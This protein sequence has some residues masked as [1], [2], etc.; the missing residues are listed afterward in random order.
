MTDEQGMRLAIDVCRLG[1]EAGQSPFGAVIVRDG[2]VIASTHNTVWADT[3]PSAHAEVNVIRAAC[4]R[5]GSI[6]LEGC[7]LYST[8]EPCPMC[9]S[10]SHWARLDRVVFGASIHDAASAG[11]SELPISSE[12]MVELGQSPLA[13]QR[14][15][16]QP[17]CVL[18]FEEWKRA[19]RSRVY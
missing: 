2:Q 9:L 19:N 3:D 18:L 4:R 17:E 10:T 1:I 16:L 11:F 6:S 14:G 7:T 13:I 15:V 5:L 12:T 8:C